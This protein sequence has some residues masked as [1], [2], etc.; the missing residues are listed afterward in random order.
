MK[1]ETRWM[2]VDDNA[3]ILFTLSVLAGSLTTAAIESHRT[4]EA[5]LAAFTAAPGQYELIITDL[6]MPGM[7]G[8]ELCRHLQAVSPAQKIFLAT[9]NGSMTAA[10]AR[11]AGFSALLKKPLSLTA[12]ETA[13]AQAGL[14]MRG[15]ES[16]LRKANIPLGGFWEPSRPQLRTGPEPTR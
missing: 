14:K 7:N 4:P 3:D 11:A 2:L 9:G 13:L 1:S 12:V 16:D 10:T 6:E 8:V 15:G 5:A